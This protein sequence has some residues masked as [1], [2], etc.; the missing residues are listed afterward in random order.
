MNQNVSLLVKQLALQ[1]AKKELEKNLSSDTIRENNLLQEKFINKLKFSCF[2]ILLDRHPT[3]IPALHFSETDKFKSQK[4]FLLNELNTILFSLRMN[5][6]GIEANKIEKLFEN[7][8]EKNEKIATFLI[9]LIKDKLNELIDSSFSIGSSSTTT[10]TII[11]N[12]NES[13]IDI[14]SLFGS[15]TIQSLNNL[16]Y[17]NCKKSSIFEMN[18]NLLFTTEINNELSNFFP[19][20]LNNNNL[21]LQNYR[22]EGN[23]TT[24]INN[25]ILCDNSLN[26]N[27]KR[28]LS[29]FTK[30]LNVKPEKRKRSIY[31]TEYNCSKLY[32]NKQYF[33]RLSFGKN[34]KVYNE[35]EIIDKSLLALQGITSSIFIYDEKSCKLIV[36]FIRLKSLS[37]L[38]LNNALQDI[39]L[40]GTYYKRLE[41]LSEYLI[42]GIDVGKCCQSFGL[43]L[44]LI[45]RWYK[46][47]ILELKNI[48]IKI[49]NNNNAENN[50][51]NN[52]ITL[53]GIIQHLTPLK[54]RLKYLSEICFC[55]IVEKNNS[56]EEDSEY[57]HSI[58]LVTRKIINLSQRILINFPKGSN[59]ID[60]L[61]TLIKQIEILDSPHV[62]ILLLLFKNSC[63]PFFNWIHQWIYN[64]II[65]GDNY[66]EFFVKENIDTTT[67]LWDNRFI[68]YYEKVPQFLKELIQ[69]LIIS[70]KILYI[71]RNSNPNHF[72]LTSDLL[73]TEIS[74]DN[75]NTVLDIKYNEKQIEIF[76]N[77]CIKLFLK[78]QELD[79]NL[80]EKRLINLQKKIQMDMKQLDFNEELLDKFQKE[81]NEIKEKLKHQIIEEYE[82]KMG[83]PLDTQQ[84][85]DSSTTFVGQLLEEDNDDN[86]VDETRRDYLYQNN[87]LNHFDDARVD[88]N[89]N[90]EEFNT[91]NNNERMKEDEDL[92]DC[93]N[94]NHSIVSEIVYERNQNNNDIV[95]NN[96]NQYLES[97]NSLLQI[98]IDIAI[99]RC[100]FT[101]ISLQKDMVDHIFINMLFNEYHLS[102]H[103]S[104]INNYF[105]F[106][107]GDI[108]DI[109]TNY[110][111]DGIMKRSLNFKDKFILNK[112]FFDAIKTSNHYNYQEEEDSLLLNNSM[113]TSD[114]DINHQHIEYNLI[115]DL[116]LDIDEKILNNED[117][118]LIDIYNI[119][120]LD[121]IKLNYSVKFP[122]NIILNESC[123]EKYIKIF[124]FLFKLKRVDLALQDIY[125]VF[126]P[127]RFIKY[128]KEP[129][130]V[131][132]LQKFRQEIQH[133][134]TVFKTFI[135]VEVIDSGFSQFVEKLIFEKESG[136]LTIER[137][138]YLHKEFLDRLLKQCL[139]NDIAKPMLDIIIKMFSLI[140]KFKYLL[141]NNTIPINEI[142]DEEE[143]NNNKGEELLV[144]VQQLRK[145]FIDCSL[146]LDQLVDQLAQQVTTSKFNLFRYHYKFTL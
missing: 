30:A 138:I 136:N 82:K 115:K 130:F 103:L 73:S 134:I 66:E 81:E 42:N 102:N 90:D 109:F 129:Q 48:I 91:V 117:K 99:K 9:F 96:L 87:D 86:M 39:A 11:E 92:V 10:T 54:E 78:Q 97:T 8:I 26:D 7:L 132:Y 77:Q 105:L 71:I 111:L 121:Y 89:D 67:N 145:E 13:I 127:F 56:S 22:K 50:N 3:Y 120:S 110:L 31:F 24:I 100:L 142:D 75:N 40:M 44:T 141:V 118:T 123:I 19:E 14:S 80:M 29:D 46:S 122:I 63:K 84:K 101:A 125:K 76:E 45:L 94:L 2:S 61:Y 57:I 98:P 107:A 113:M 137:L 4:A 17:T 65:E 131:K 119:N 52:S 1:I 70:G 23:F 16:N 32:Q 83:I 18:N 15:N 35:I 12:N 126:Q 49:Y 28:P 112:T 25:N 144:I 36:Q 43:T 27:F 72:L 106:K 51:N 6:R 74:I 95:N 33:D 58:Q 64:G 104:L 60:Y 93:N 139:L 69:K 53:L 68:I 38:S 5:D 79:K 88:V 108:H 37:L 128:K 85:E 55:D 146:F 59:L 116:S 62:N 124:K 20:L 114:T 135:F 34:F 41:L 21:S 143:N 133:F 47:C 140:L